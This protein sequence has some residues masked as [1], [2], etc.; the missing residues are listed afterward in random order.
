[1][2][3]YEP[4]GYKPELKAPHKTWRGRV[5]YDRKL[6]PFT[7]RDFLR[8][9]N[10]LD[11]G[12]HDYEYIFQFLNMVFQLFYRWVSTYL[13]TFAFTA[14]SQVKDFVRNTIA[15][16][17]SFYQSVFWD[18]PDSA[19]DAAQRILELLYLL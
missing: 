17:I 9:G 16:M 8:I 1:M 10:R 5:V 11:L 14:A 12:Y 6:H 2:I 13:G 15:S 18:G 19:K 7:M 3:V 4:G